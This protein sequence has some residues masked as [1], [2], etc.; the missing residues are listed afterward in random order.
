MTAASLAYGSLMLTSLRGLSQF[1]LLGG[2]GMLLV[3]LTTFVVVPALVAWIER[4]F[5]DAMTAAPP[6][7][8]LPCAW[9]G[10]AIAHR[11]WTV[12]VLC[13]ISVAALSRPA[14]RWAREPLDYSPSA[15]RTDN[16]EV[17]R[18]WGIMYDLGMGNLGA[19]HIARDGV[20]LVDT[21]EQ[22]DAVADAL[23][24]QDQALGE[25]RVLEEVRTLNKILPRDQAAKLAILDRLRR[26]LDRYRSYI[27]DSEWQDL[28]DF[29]PPDDLHIVGIPDLPR[30][31]RD[32]FTEVDGTIGRLIGIDADFTN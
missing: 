29:R 11:P 10:R 1:G 24:A 23:W 15:L 28:K 30:R 21:P 7:W 3:W 12:A 20:I 22:A 25:R 6:P 19:G 5:P 26:T 14:L 18:L 16:P 27:D 17:N 9:L 31:L 8:P 4:R 2:I 32:N 13:M